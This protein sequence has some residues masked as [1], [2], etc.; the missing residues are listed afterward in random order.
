[1]VGQCI[2]AGTPFAASMKD[3]LDH[4]TVEGMADTPYAIP[5]FQVSAHNPKVNVPVLWW[6]S[7]GHTHS[8]FVMETLVDE[9]AARA[10]MDPFGYRRKLLKPEARRLRATLD[11]LEAKSATWSRRLPKNHAWGVSCHESFE[12]G[13]GCAL[14]VAFAHKRPR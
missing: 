10:H 12:T 11:L 6:R 5:N 7:V 9:L 2:L 3:N 8:A 13:V 14:E 4:T 1:M